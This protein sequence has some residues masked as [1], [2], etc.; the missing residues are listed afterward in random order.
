MEKKLNRAELLA[1]VALSSGVLDM[2]GHRNQL[3]F[4]FASERETGVY[5][6]MSVVAMRLADALV[7][8]FGRAKAA[9]VVRTHPDVW[10]E[11]VR[12]IENEGAADM[13]FFAGC[14]PPP[15]ETFTVSGGTRAEIAADLETLTAEGGASSAAFID[16]N[17]LIADVRAR[18]RAGGIDLD[19]PVFV[20][21]PQ[22]EAERHE[23]LHETIAARKQA[24]KQRSRPDKHE[25]PSGRA[26]RERI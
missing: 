21:T 12:R 14:T 24:R 10:F 25:T 20:L 11:L 2:M 9:H 5:G 3:P 8:T 18:A 16:M 1:S 19:G 26:R 4:P 23:R 15:D 7:P 6:A 13:L 17:K 22:E